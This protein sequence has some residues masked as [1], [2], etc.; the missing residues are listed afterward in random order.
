[1]EHRYTRADH[2]ALSRAG[3]QRVEGSKPDR[4][5][6]EPVLSQVDAG[7]SQPGYP[8]VRTRGCE[9]VEG[10]EG[11]LAGWFSVHIAHGY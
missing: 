2:S 4:Q 9:G 7:R 5:V 11:Q 6:W 8:A 10:D 1:M 3:G